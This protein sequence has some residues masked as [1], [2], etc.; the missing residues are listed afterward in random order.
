MTDGLI[1]MCPCKALT[2]SSP[3]SPIAQ[4]ICHCEDCRSST[5]NPFTTTAFFRAEGT[6]IDGDVAQQTFVGGSGRTTTRQSCARCGSVLFD[7]SENFPG[8]I[9]VLTQHIHPPFIAKPSAHMWVRSKVADLG[10]SDSLPQ[11]PEGV[12]K[13]S[14]DPK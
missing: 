5:G 2:F 1:A 14:G 9:G 11:F 12:L 7:T 3:A 13:A 6:V 10:V 8:I 4:L